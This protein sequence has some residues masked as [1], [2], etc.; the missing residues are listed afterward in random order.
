M[1]WTGINLQEV[2]TDSV[3]KMLKSN[4]VNIFCLPL[5]YRK[6]GNSPQ[7]QFTMQAAKN[8]FNFSYEV[9]NLKNHDTKSTESRFSVVRGQGGMVVH[10]KKSAYEIISTE[11]VSTIGQGFIDQGRNVSTFT[12]KHGEVIGLTIT[13]GERQTAVGDVTYTASITIPNNGGGVGYLSIHQTR[14][15][16][17]NGAVT[18]LGGKKGIVKIPHNLTYEYA[19]NMAKD[20]IE[21]FVNLAK[22]VESRDAEMNAS[23]LTTVEVRSLL[24]EWFYYNETPLP[25]QAATSLNEFRRILFEDF[26]SLKM[27]VQNRYNELLKALAL[28]MGYNTELG[29]KTS[30]YTVHAVVTNYLSRRIEKSQSVDPTEISYQKASEKID[31]LHSIL[32]KVLVEA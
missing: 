30:Q 13:L 24:N 18:K 29:L 32:P 19:L 10:T 26:Q 21:Q 5:Y 6:T 23:E 27:S 11:A 1:L 2:C 15:I 9:E 8:L 12:K 16:C 14:L 4:T 3:N 7:N 20:S 31:S 17:T 22:V 28:E 25:F